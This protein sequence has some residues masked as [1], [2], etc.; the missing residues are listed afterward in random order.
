M[1]YISLL[2]TQKHQPTLDTIVGL[3]EGLETTMT[4][5]VSEIENL[6]RED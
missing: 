6:L 4:A 3:S 1:R 2:E 5:L